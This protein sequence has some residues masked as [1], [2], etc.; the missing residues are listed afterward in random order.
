[1]P[2]TIDLRDEALLDEVS[3]R[4]AALYEK[5]LKHLLEPDFNGQ[6]AAIH[7]DTVEYEVAS[8]ASVA[9]RQLRTRHP[10]GLVM[11]MDIGPVADDDSLTLR[12]LGKQLHSGHGK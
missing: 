6:I 1:M 12:M 10:N 8:T 5:H 4:G 3:L 11:V 9:L 2:A 7:L